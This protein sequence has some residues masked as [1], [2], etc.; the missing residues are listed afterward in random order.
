LGVPLVPDF[1]LHLPQAQAQRC[2]PPDLLDHFVPEPL[3]GLENRK[4]QHHASTTITH[5]P[6]SP[7]SQNP[8][9]R[10]Q[11][12]STVSVS[13]KVVNLP[14][15]TPTPLHARL[16]SSN[17]APSCIALPMQPCLHLSLKLRF[18]LSADPVLQPLLQV[19]NK[20]F[21]TSRRILYAYH[22]AILGLV[23]VPRQNLPWIPVV[24]Y[25]NRL[26]YITHAL[27]RSRIHCK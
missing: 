22:D 4:G 20:G 18:V 2:P 3:T 14:C 11:L 1:P 8:K 19:S 21:E 5:H 7:D 27:M 13:A 16:V 24:F 15:A 25:F 26:R 12:P 23:L 9:V 10:H 6:R 17:S